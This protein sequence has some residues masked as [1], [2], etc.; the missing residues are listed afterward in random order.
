MNF[1]HLDEFVSYVDDQILPA[2]TDLNNLAKT[3]RKHVQ[4]LVYTNLV[5]RF[6]V[7]IDQS[8]LSNC[9]EEPL[10]EAAIKRMD[11][12]INE[13]DLIRLLMLGSDLESAINERIQS[14]IRNHELRARHSKKV[15]TWLRVCRMEEKSLKSNRVNSANGEILKTFKQQEKTTPASI[16][17]YTDWLYSRRN[18][19]VHGGN[20][21]ILLANNVSQLKSLYGCRPA[22]TYSLTL[23]SIK[24]AAHF[25]KSL[26]ALAK[27]G[28]PESEA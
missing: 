19:V 24:V 14:S 10:L 20:A 22:K 16:L 25:Y 13:G 1:D 5:D 6:D 15:G 4:K 8:L 28:V 7:T 27:D 2:T 11:Q 3:S 17:G 23:G 9:R 26:V 12:G 18:A 21:R